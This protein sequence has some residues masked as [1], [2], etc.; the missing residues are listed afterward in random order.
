MKQVRKEKCVATYGVTCSSVGEDNKNFMLLWLGSTVYTYYFDWFFLKPYSYTWDYED[1]SRSMMASKMLS[2]IVHYGSEEKYISFDY[3]A[4]SNDLLGD[5]T[6]HI[7][8]VSGQWNIPW[9]HETFQEHALLNLDG[10]VFHVVND[11]TDEHY[12]WEYPGHERMQFNM[13]DNYDGSTILT[14]VY[15]EH[16]IWTRGT[17]WV[18]WIKWFTK[19]MIITSLSL[20]F[21]QE[22]GKGKGS[23]KGGTI[24]HS[25]DM[26]D[27]ETSEEA[28]VRYCNKSGHTFVSFVTEGEGKVAE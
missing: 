20:S 10:S 13:V 22:V 27:G 21:D 23:W 26:L 24:G 1:Q 19:P 6:G 12:A 14:T 7:P 3:G 17:S 4:D 5:K 11:I 25:I 2:L 16:R 18:S 9:A 8:T 15:C 28:C